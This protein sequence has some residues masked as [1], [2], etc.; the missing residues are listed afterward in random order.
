MSGLITKAAMFAACCAVA[1]AAAQA[2][3]SGIRRVAYVQSSITD[4]RK[5]TVVLLDGSRWQTLSSAVL[6]PVSDVIIVADSGLSTL[7]TDGWDVPVRLISG[8]P[9]TLSGTLTRVV[10]ATPDGAVLT[11]A[12]GS[13]LDVPEYDRFQT[14]FWLPP[15][16]ALLTSGRLHLF[17]L[18]KVKGIWVSPR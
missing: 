15:Y 6:L 2:P 17:N 8:T 10:H 5:D 16:P 13:M 12:D 1:T 14:S 3:E 11:L 7:F 4:I 18:K 9:P